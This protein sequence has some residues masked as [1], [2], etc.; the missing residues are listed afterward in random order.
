MGETDEMAMAG[1]DGPPEAGLEVVERALARL[2]LLE[3]VG[4]GDVSAAAVPEGARATAT[5]RAREPGVLSG[6]GAAISVFRAVDADVEVETLVEPGSRFAA[7]D[8]ILRARGAARS[9]LT[10][11]RSALN[12]LQHLSGVATAT[13]ACVDA[14]GG[15]DARVR[16]SDTR[17][18]TPGLRL[19]EKEAV[20]HGGGTNHRLGLYDAIMIKDNHIDAAGGIAKAAEAVRRSSPG[21]PVIIEARNLEEAREAAIAD[22]GRILLDNMSPERVRE[23]VRAIREIDA[24]RVAA[25]GAPADPEWRWIP[26][27]KRP[28][29]PRTQIEVSGR[30][31]LSSIASYADLDIDFV[32]IGRITHSAPALDLGLD[33]VLG[34]EGP[35]AG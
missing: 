1:K 22:A 9:L 23:C 25:A 30:L 16:L 15:P 35:A 34:G 32:S 27:T 2:A 10:A 8:E 17:K 29:D 18:T 13:R 24:T 5:I 7:G 12:F 14:L 19:L 20:L 26:G 3:D 21:V 11:E 28:G 31:E 4:E 33:L 6:L